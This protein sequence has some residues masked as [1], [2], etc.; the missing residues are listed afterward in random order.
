[1][2]DH[3]LNIP[4]FKIGSNERVLLFDENKAKIIIPELIRLVRISLDRLFDEQKKL[5]MPLRTLIVARAVNI[6]VI[7]TRFISR[8]DYEFK[9][10]A[11]DW[12]LL[13]AELYNV[14]EPFSHFTRAFWPD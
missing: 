10:L 1:M 4:K 6:S 12:A 9:D 11:R 5:N 3:L 8:L 7:L 2:T 13:M 14:I